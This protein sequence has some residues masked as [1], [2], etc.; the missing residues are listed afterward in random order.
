LRL[1]SIKVVCVVALSRSLLIG[2]SIDISR[3]SFWELS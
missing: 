2:C 3:N 1:A